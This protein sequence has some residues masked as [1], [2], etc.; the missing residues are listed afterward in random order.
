MIEKS[1]TKRIYLSTLPLEQAEPALVQFKQEWIQKHNRV[2]KKYN[3]IKLKEFLRYAV[4]EQETLYPSIPEAKFD[5][6]LWNKL[7]IS[8]LGPAKKYS[9][10]FFVKRSVIKQTAEAE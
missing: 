7:V 3:H 2:A 5:R 4:E 6:V 8:E 1:L 10:P 9:N